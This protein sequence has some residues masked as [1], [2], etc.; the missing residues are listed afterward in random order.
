MASTI[1]TAAHGTPHWSSSGAAPVFGPNDWYV[2]ENQEEFLADPNRLDPTWRDFFSQAPPVTD[3]TPLLTPASVA[4]L[5]AA[6]NIRTRPAAALPPPT[7]AATPAA[8]AVTR[9]RHS[10]RPPGGDGRGWD[11][12]SGHP[13]AR[14]RGRG[15]DKYDSVVGGTDRDVAAWRASEADGRQPVVI[16]T[17]RIGTAAWRVGCRI[18]RSCSEGSRRAN[19]RHGEQTSRR[20]EWLRALRA[21][22]VGS[23]SSC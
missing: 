13:A 3:H 7:P 14:R 9:P 5:P 17:A 10:R 12:F 22:W 18:T 21:P 20:I 15:G 19:A 2:K 8:P 6:V 23:G 11:R 16:T 1:G 4:V